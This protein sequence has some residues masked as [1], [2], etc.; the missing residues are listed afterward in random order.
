MINKVKNIESSLIE[1][2]DA[3]K[4]LNLYVQK[5]EKDIQDLSSVELPISQNKEG[6]LEN[7]NKKTP[8]VRRVEDQEDRETVAPSYTIQVVGLGTTKVD[9]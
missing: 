6:L 4:S 3:L 1:I 5:I 7:N 8:L 2:K 9:F